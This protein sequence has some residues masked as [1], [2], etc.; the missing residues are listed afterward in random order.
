MFAACSVIAGPLTLDS[1]AA[2]Q[3]TACVASIWACDV[4]RGAWG[5]G[6]WHHYAD[7][8]AVYWAVST[9]LPHLHLASVGWSEV[10]SLP[11]SIRLGFFHDK[12]ILKDSPQNYFDSNYLKTVCWKTKYNKQCILHLYI[13]HG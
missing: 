9:K 11:P 1:L 6:T 7:A 12:Y 5:H 2:V 8:P 10:H 13:L 4:T 3:P